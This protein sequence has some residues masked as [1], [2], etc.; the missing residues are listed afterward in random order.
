MEAWKINN[1]ENINIFL[2]EMGINTSVIQKSRSIICKVV[3]L[4]ADLAYTNKLQAPPRE[5][6]ITIR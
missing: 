2:L 6:C 5:N 4:S 1:M 3:L